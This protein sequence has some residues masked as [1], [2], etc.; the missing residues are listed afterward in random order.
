[1]PGG[2]RRRCW[3]SVDRDHLDI[4][5]QG[6]PLPLGDWGPHRTQDL[7]PVPLFARWAEKG[8]SV[9]RAPL[10]PAVLVPRPPHVRALGTNP[11]R[12]RAVEPLSPRRNDTRKGHN[13]PGRF[14]RPQCTPNPSDGSD[15]KRR[16]MGFVR[17]CWGREPP[18]PQPLHAQC[19]RRAWSR[20]PGQ[21]RERRRSQSDRSCGLGVRKQRLTASLVD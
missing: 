18:D 21:K 12:R 11:G 5:R 13:A 3:S 9:Q 7:T 19:P 6:A 14:S 16:S 1:M 2:L 17:S 10:F 4:G 8:P 20:S 15:L